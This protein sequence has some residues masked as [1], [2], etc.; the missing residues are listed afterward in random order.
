MEG[1]HEKREE[2]VKRIFYNNV[3]QYHPEFRLLNSFSLCTV[4]YK[5]SWPCTRFYSMCISLVAH[6]T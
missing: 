2:D 3:K 1:L 4:Q 5:S 6:T